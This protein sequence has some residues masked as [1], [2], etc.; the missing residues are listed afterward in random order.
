V[1][2]LLK[3]QVNALFILGTFGE[4]LLFSLEERRRF[5]EQVTGFVNKRVPVIVHA[6]HM[7]VGKTRQLIRIAQDSGA[8]AV[9][10]V[11][12]FYYSLSD[13]AIEEYFIKIFKE[14]KNFAFFIYNILQCTVNEINLSIL[15]SKIR[16]FVRWRNW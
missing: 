4:G 13:E 14:F 2:F 5:V 10:L 8:D 12:P 1:D 11:P 7:E 6:S 9:A 15:Q 16:S 3:R